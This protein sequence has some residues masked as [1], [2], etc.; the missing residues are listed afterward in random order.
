LPSTGA[1]STGAPKR[2]GFLPVFL[3]S[4]V[5]CIAFVVGALIVLVLLLPTLC[6]TLAASIVR[7]DFNQ[8]HRGTLEIGGLDLAWFQRQTVR[9]AILL[10]PDKTEVARATATL[11]SLLDLVRSGGSRIGKVD[12]TVNAELVA[13]DAGVTNLERALESSKAEPKSE[14]KTDESSGSLSKKLA[15]LDLDLTLKSQRLSWSDA[16]TRRLGAP[17]EIRDLSAVVK[18]RPGAPLTAQAQASIAADSP[19]ELALDATVNDLARTSAPA[20]KGA[21]PKWPWGRI[22]MNLSL[23]GFSSGLLDGLANQH[24]RLKDILGP[25]FDLTAKAAGA[26]PDAGDVSI[27]L[28]AGATKARF[29]GRFENGAFHLSSEPDQGISFPM[30]RKYIEDLVVPTLPAGSKLSFG[31]STPSAAP[32]GASSGTPG[33]APAT[34][35]WSLRIQKLDLPIPDASARSAKTLAPFLDRVTG[36]VLVD[37]PADIGVEMPSLASAGGAPTLRRT[38]INV[39]TAPGAPLVA[40]LSSELDMHGKASIAA[41]VTLR[42]PWKALAA[43]ALPRAD[44][45]IEL[46]DLGTEAIDALAGQGGKLVGALGPKISVRVRAKDASP[47]SGS[48]SLEIGAEHFDLAWSGKLEQGRV[49][50]SGGDTLT[51]HAEPPPEFIAREIAAVVPPGI[52]LSVGAGP[53]KIEGREITFV[54]PKSGAPR[55]AQAA[56]DPFAMFRGALAAQVSCD[57]PPIRVSN[58]STRAAKLPLEIAGAHAALTLSMDGKCALAL[59]STID[60]GTKATFSA[61]VGA[62]DAWQLAAA[63]GLQAIPPIDVKV[64]LEGLSTSTIG[65]LA[66]AESLASDILGP[67]VSIA[68][69]ARGVS[70]SGGSVRADVTAPSLSLAMRGKIENGALRSTGDEGLDIDASPSAEGLSRVL[71]PHLPAGARVTLASTA[72][73][74]NA[75]AAKSIRLRVRDLVVPLPSFDNSSAGAAGSAV[76]EGNASPAGKGAKTAAPGGTEIAATM[77]RASA[78]ARLEIDR[79][80]IA[81]STPNAKTTSAQK[82]GGAASIPDL[83]LSGLAL[84]I[85]VAPKQPLAIKLDATVE[86]G[87]T[88]TLAAEVSVKDPWL[89][90]KSAPHALPP[91]QGKVRVAGLP[92][93]S[94][95]AYL[96]QRELFAKFFGPAVEMSADVDAKS[97]DEGTFRADLKS[98]TTTVSTSGRVEK[99]AIV[100]TGAQGLDAEVHLAAGWLESQVTP[101]LPAGARLS[102]PSDAAPIKLSVRDVH[103]TLAEASVPAAKP[104]IT[105][106]ADGGS[107]GGSGGPSTQTAEAA[108]RAKLALIS[109]L[110]L[111]A[112]FTV[113]TLTYSDAKTDA[114]KQPVTIR[115]LNAA[116]D[117]APGKPPS[118]ELHGKIEA[119][120]PGDLNATVHALDALDRLAD[121][122]GLDTFRVAIDVSAAHIPTALIDALASQDGLLVGALGTRLD[123]SIKSDSLSR[124]QGTFVASLSSDQHSVRVV[125]GR[126]DHG[127]VVIDKVDGLVAKVA[128]SPLVSKQVVGSLVPMVVDVAKPQG[129][130][131]VSFAVDNLR[132]PKDGDLGKLDALVRVNLGEVSYRLLPGLEAVLGS[133]APKTVKLPELKLP[134]QHGVVSYAGIPIQIGGHDLAF[135]GSFNLKDKTFD[136]ATEVPLGLL[137]KSV[138]NELDKLRG[139]LGADTMVPVEIKGTWSSPHV[140]IG[141][142]FVKKALENAAKKEI[143]GLLDGLLKKKKKDE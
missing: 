137:G 23:K 42:D 2:R 98:P 90:L 46:I 11:P 135:N 94:I 38:R 25:R 133:A 33:S 74:A 26:T 122:K 20:S 139:I 27:A 117:L 130:E 17:F 50:S 123:M 18:A 73:G 134:I 7:K 84:T 9:D 143:P 100:C 35:V 93:A 65:K 64:A 107:G 132:W 6:S 19:G 140:S 127:D 113:P 89:A 41:E 1:T 28:D 120:T 102:A 53:I 104:V 105:G 5:G 80:V 69:D 45:H 29:A 61:S 91:V 54:L 51:V 86:A 103:V 111:R 138:A 97:A 8:K 106:P 95:D 79:V 32:G 55:P 78:K 67:N 70:A 126:L 30:P 109:K 118:A 12:L 87:G 24:G 58:E 82:A 16:D 75:P 14:K 83:T 141:G 3:K 136:L 31:P 52:E 22:D 92:S 115:D 88:G 56:A 62:A 76:A 13:D 129:S 142:D 4:T 49:R 72:A 37:L 60:A 81:N 39:R 44:A 119:E 47:D 96:G 99:G 15:D 85:D 34:Q 125:E 71:A 59:K 101:L 116:V 10:A 36:D 40:G 128:L 21:S 68:L 57:L 121:E 124:E 108:M 66:G 114:A 110:A 63:R 112:S 77:E 48:L 43:G 131:P